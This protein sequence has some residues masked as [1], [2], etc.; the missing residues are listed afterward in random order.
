MH[1]ILGL[2]RSALQRCRRCFED[3]AR[4]CIARLRPPLRVL[5]GQYIPQGGRYAITPNHYYRPGFASQW[6]ALAI[7]AS[8][9]AD[10]RW[11]MTGELTFPGSW[12][13][14]L[15]MPSSR[16]VLSHIARVYDFTTMPP[17]PPRRGD[18]EARALAV[19]SILRYVAHNH[20]AILALAPE[21]G[22]QPGGRLCMPPAGGGRFCALLAA[23]G[24]LF[25]PVGVYERDGQL[26]LNFGQ[27][28]QLHVA[29]TKDT[30][31]KDRL[32]AYTVMSHIAALLP[33]ELRG[34]F[35]EVHS[36]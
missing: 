19:L 25:L 33:V 32:A 15:G 1:V 22:D 4:A 28:Y 35:G 36:I 14:P 3:D 31:Q 24:L 30:E 12:L 27:P 16:F 9:S 34:E 26:T 11:I 18:V 5:G 7:S 29:D 13:A 23:A 8:V 21:G 17:M 20:D 6:S 10:V 2:M